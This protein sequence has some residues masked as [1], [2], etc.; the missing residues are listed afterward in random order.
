MSSGRRRRSSSGGAGARCSK[1]FSKGSS[2]AGGCAMTRSIR[3]IV[4]ARAFGPPE[5]L[6]MSEASLFE[7]ATF[8][9]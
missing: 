7:F 3:V 5:D 4:I 1:P 9:R 6:G 2:L 8:G